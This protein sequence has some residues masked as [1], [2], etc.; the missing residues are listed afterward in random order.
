[1]VMGCERLHLRINYYVVRVI[2]A[3][4]LSSSRADENNLEFISQIKS[5]E[6]VIA[7]ENIARWESKVCT[8]Q[9]NDQD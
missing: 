6:L 5:R 2:V 4:I 7:K 1:M 9:D 8:S 3:T